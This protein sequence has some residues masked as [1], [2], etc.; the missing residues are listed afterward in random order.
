MDSLGGTTW[1]VPG[2]LATYLGPRY[3]LGYMVKGK[4]EKK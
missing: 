2:Y 4:G 1:V 3:L